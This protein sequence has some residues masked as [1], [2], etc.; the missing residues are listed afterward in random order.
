MGERQA[1]VIAA[2]FG[3]ALDQH[4]IGAE[5]QGS[6]R[7]ELVHPFGAQLEILEAGPQDMEG[8]DAGPRAWPGVQRP[9]LQAAAGVFGSRGGSMRV[10]G[11]PRRLGVK[12]A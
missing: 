11:S 5:L 12:A 9:R 8:T 10:I 7:A 2:A 1:Q 3:N 4:P 6:Q